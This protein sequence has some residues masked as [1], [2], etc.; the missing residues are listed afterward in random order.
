MSDKSVF[1]SHSSQDDQVVA[2]IR[3]AL[4]GLRIETWADS[5]RLAGGD[6][7][8]PSIKKA[9]E[10]AS[11]FLAILSP[12]AINS[13]WV[14]KEIKHALKVGKNV[15]P[16]LL[17][18]IKPSALHLWFGK[19]PVAVKLG[20]GPGAV[21]AALPG[22]L[23]ALGERLPDEASPPVPARAAPIAD[24]V[25]ELTD[26]AIDTAEGKRRA[27]AAATLA[28]HPPDGGPDVESKRYRFTAPLGPIEADELAWYLER[29]VNWPSGVFQER[30]RRV[31]ADLPRWGDLLYDT[32]NA[33]VARAA[34]E[35]WKAT[36]EG[37]ERRFTVKVDKELV[38]AQD[39]RQREADEA[40]T[41]LLSLPWELI[42]DKGGFLFQDARGVR[43]RRSLPNRN[44]Q[45][46]LATRPPIRVLLASPRPED[47]PYFDHRISARPLVEALSKLGDLAD[48][49]LL[50]PPTF[51]ALQDELQRAAKAKKP[52]HVVHFDGHGIYDRKLG[53]GALC[54]ENPARRTDLVMADKLAEVI[55]G[56]RVPLFFLDACQTAKAVADPTA[57]VAGKL[58]ESGVA[59]VAAMSHSVLVE[60]ARRFVAVF[61]EHLMSGKR[62]G[63]AML[64]GQ[65][66]LRMDTFRGKVFT[67]ELNLQDWFVP[68]L[69]Q[70][71][72]DPQLIREVPA[73]Q[74][75]S[76]IAQQREL[77][78]GRV[79]AE[80]EH[81][82]VGR[83]RELLAAE[84][85]LAGE[86]YV[87]FQGDGGE[88]KTTLAAEL[89]RWLVFTQRFQRGAFAR[90][91]QDGDA[92]KVLYA[93]GEQLVPNYL[94]R[95]A[96]NP[97]HALQLVERALAEQATVIVLD[98]M[99]SV[100]PPAPGSEAHLAFEPETL[101]GIVGLCQA[102]T[103]QGDTRLIFTS[104]EPLPE[105]FSRNLV[106]VDRLD[107]S[108]AIRL[109][110]SVLGEGKL[111][112]HAADPG[113]SEQEIEKLV[114]AVGCHARSLVLLAGEVA[115]SGVR[116]ATEKLRELMASLEAKYPG[117]RERSL[118]ASVEL[119]LRRL[120]AE[121]RCKI[122]PLG[123]FQGGGS[124]LALGVTLGLEPR[125][126]VTLARVLVGVGLAEQLQFGYLRLDPALAPALLA[127]MSAE[128][129]EAARAAWAEAMAAMVDFLCEQLSKDANL[130]LNLALLELSN[131][132]AALDYLREIAAPERVVGLA[133][134]LETLIAPLAC[135]KALA[136][137]VE[138]RT[139]ATQQLG[140]WSHARFEAEQAAI[141]RLIEQGRRS[142][143]VE[144]A[145]SLLEGAR[146][147]GEN[148]Y[149]G[150]ASDLTIV[151]I[152]L[153]R[154]LR[155]SG[156][157]EE[158]V[159]HL[160]VARE[161]FQ[162]L[163][164]RRMANVALAEKANCLRDLGRY[165]EAAAAYE[166]AIRI[167]EELGDPRSIA[168]GKN[169]LATVRMLQER[170]PEALDLY[171]G[172]RN[173]FK[174]LGEPA[175]VATIWHL[176][177]MV[178]EK[179]GQYDVAEKAYQESLKLNVQ[180]ANRPGE[181]STLNQ[182]GSLYSLVARREE[183]V[184]FG[185][186]AAEVSM[187]LKDL[188]G[189][190]VTRS[191]IAGELITLKR[192]DEARQELLRAIE[193]K[194][195][196]GHVAQ[197]WKTFAILSNLERAVGNEPEA[198]KARNQAMQAYLAYRRAGGESQTPGGQLCALVA[199]QPDAARG[200]LAKL[201]QSPDLPADLR[202]LIPLLEAVLAGS[203]DP[204][205]AED[206]SL[207]YDDAAELL[208]LI[209]SL[210]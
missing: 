129:R 116:H 128:E 154:A 93:I 108:D 188:R 60:T 70:E 182:L 133:T 59:S 56:H 36:P 84:R 104:R 185:R 99:E 184:R 97:A 43:V 203:R 110:G 41:L 30:A 210:S 195:P 1:I 57:S 63:Q 206:P 105:P 78:L 132:L 68:V 81:G 94:S 75:Q 141:E 158:A 88:G 121:T 130:A 156:A 181:A 117:E 207:D 160:D 127:E 86:R 120:P 161:R 66:A 21:S 87:V 20:V 209:E 58:L 178:H 28:Y 205:L 166:E 34:F 53:L 25:L 15:I 113:E 145:R 194:K 201:R 5:Q 64:A 191:N 134:S 199:R 122:R 11:H 76:I 139:E 54:F 82:F 33:D 143:A 136:R 14:A 3:Q 31:E 149:D 29:Y 55:R 152:T 138:I 47:E 123:V 163:G 109:V 101:E 147:A 35:A 89:A 100:L 150:A 6:E 159:A 37:T 45:V 69:F 102:L 189:E 126:C 157:A 96:Q 131:L 115:A 65:R 73:E 135:P 39:P 164:E 198:R 77:A 50:T 137:V 71:E 92:R 49:T 192:Y 72:Q 22:L 4:E 52:Y 140:A 144:A 19:E 208:L 24:L 190:G 111:M 44:T 155:T 196:F 193:C 38:D 103:K 32:L 107:R 26:P 148:A 142:E 174:Q 202:A 7:L 124:L 79:P 12:N 200:L 168:A 151:Q 171:H 172:V 40:A 167:G 177:G 180:T 119:S 74:V 2:E 48:F 169:Q 153:G 162:N 67:G 8:E 95:A 183:A 62:V 80:P 16:V 175:S 165:D 13:A 170:Y 176:I 18:G 90:L 61:Y 23:A 91:D 118:L 10:S 106:K 27:T 83:S 42:H 46:A 204:A 187:E 179:T 51:Q 85:L 186:Q 9:I 112:P 173:I 114:D 98:N 17:P 146:A 197:P 125:E